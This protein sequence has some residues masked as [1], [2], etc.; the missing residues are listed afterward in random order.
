MPSLAAALE[1]GKINPD[2]RLPAAKRIGEG[3]R[4]LTAHEAA[5]EGP[6]GHGRDESGA[7]RQGECL[8]LEGKHGGGCGSV[9][10]VEKGFCELGGDVVRSVVW[11]T[12]ARAKRFSAA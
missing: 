8:T 9:N 1:T 7:A 3:V 11:V 12:K 6:T 5:A 10:C 2:P 4:E